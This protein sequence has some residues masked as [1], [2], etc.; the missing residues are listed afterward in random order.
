[1]YLMHHSLK[2]RHVEAILR[3]RNH[4]YHDG[5]LQYFEGCPK[6]P[7][8]FHLNNLDIE[9]VSMS[10]PELQIGLRVRF[11]FLENWIKN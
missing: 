7:S 1:M 2:K 8:F 11:G 9:V 10:S 6:L 5:F 4:F 3:S